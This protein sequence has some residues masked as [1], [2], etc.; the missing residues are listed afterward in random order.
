MD[1]D[2]KIVLSVTFGLLPSLTWLFYYLSRDIHPEPKKM[3]TRVFLW[4]SFITIPVFF[5][6]IALTKLFGIEG[7]SSLI[8]SLIYWFI[9]ISFTEELFK[10]LVFRTKVIN[11]P[12]LD[13]PVDVLLYMVVAAIGFTAVENILYLLSPTGQMLVSDTV[14]RTLIISLIRFIGATFLHTL[15]SAIIGCFMA[16]SFYLDKKKY[17]ITAIGFILAVV[18]HG[19]YDF[20]IITLEGNIRFIIP[21]IIILLLALFVFSILEKLKKMK[22]VCKTN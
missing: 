20:S 1:Y 7:T 22:S 2:Y 3:I 8:K 10:Y 19:L 15:C 9:I 18:L 5:V 13:E 12:H 11:N 17:L 4:G 16:F 14:N 6:Q 21:L